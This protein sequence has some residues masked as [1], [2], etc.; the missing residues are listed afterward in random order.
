ME[1]FIVRIWVPGDGD[2]APDQSLHGQIVHLATGATRNFQ[3]PEG[4]MAFIREELGSP[5]LLPEAKRP[6]P[7]DEAPA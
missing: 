1:S 4:L 6:Q 7:M 3:E 2:E 5:L